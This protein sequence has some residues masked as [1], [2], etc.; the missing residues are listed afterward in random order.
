MRISP[1]GVLIDRTPFLLVD[2]QR[3]GVYPDIRFGGERRKTERPR[4]PGR[5]TSSMVDEPGPRL[6]VRRPG[7]LARNASADAGS[8]L[9]AAQ[10]ASRMASLSF[11]MSQTE[12]VRLTTF[13]AAGRR[14]ASLFSGR[15]NAGAQTMSLDTRR[16]ANGVY[17]LRLEAGDKSLDPA[18]SGPIAQSRWDTI[19]E[20]RRVP[21]SAR[22]RG[23]VPVFRACPRR[24]AV[25]TG[26][27]RG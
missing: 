24:R 20:I 19:P 8:A 3:A 2:A 6:Y 16:L 25:D 27:G 15:L 9:R 12:Q 7:G 13:D 17:F 10:P 21:R 14:R 1:E 5:R 22:M 23:T 26:S 11:N 4:F 18:G